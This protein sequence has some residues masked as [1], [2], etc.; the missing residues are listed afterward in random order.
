[1]ISAE[2]CVG[3]KTSSSW[4]AW[5]FCSSAETAGDEIQN[6]KAQRR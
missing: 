5:F 6:K 2:Q 3:M 1:L 4:I